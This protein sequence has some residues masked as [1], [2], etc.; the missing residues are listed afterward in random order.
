MQS[1]REFLS[2]VVGAAV[3]STLPKLTSAAGTSEKLNLLIITADD[4]N[5][6]SCG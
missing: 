3:A 4:L 2:T 1:R 6:E 5:C